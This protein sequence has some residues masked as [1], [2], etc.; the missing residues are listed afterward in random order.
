MIRPDALISVLQ[1][2]VKMFEMKDMSIHILGTI[3]ED[4]MFHRE[5]NNWE[6]HWEEIADELGSPCNMDYIL[7]CT[8]WAKQTY[9]RLDVRGLT[10][11]QVCNKISIFY[12]HKT[13]RRLM[14]DHRW[15]EG[16]FV[17]QPDE[18]NVFRPVMYGS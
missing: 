6:I 4:A 10:N 7:L 2:V 11:R 15:I 17:P 3:D 1:K 9:R 14:G 13:Y 12:L 5:L 8:N 16:W 18:P